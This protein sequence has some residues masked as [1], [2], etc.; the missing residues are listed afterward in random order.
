[1][2]EIKVRCTPDA[3]PATAIRTLFCRVANQEPSD[4]NPLVKTDFNLLLEQIAQLAFEEGRAFEKMHPK[5]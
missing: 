2:I 4:E 3:Q 1:M 5:L